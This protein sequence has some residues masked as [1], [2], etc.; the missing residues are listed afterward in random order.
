MVKSIVVIKIPICPACLYAF[1][2][3]YSQN[4]CAIK[5]RI[6]PNYGNFKEV[7]ICAPIVNPGKAN[8]AILLNN[9]FFFDSS[10]IVDF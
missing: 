6:N 9:F 3:E 10:F 8:W 4:G 1:H 2:D 7:A 5:F